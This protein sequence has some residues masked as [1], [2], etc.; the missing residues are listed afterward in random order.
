VQ[1]KAILLA[2][3]DSISAFD[4]AIEA[5]T[6]LFQHHH[7]DVVQRFSADRSRVSDQVRLATVANLR[8]TIPR[9]QVKPGQGCI[10]YATSHGTAEG[11]HL[12]QDQSSGYLLHPRSLQSIVQAACGEAPTIMV[13]SG[14]YSG[15]YLR[16]EIVAPHVI[17]M[18]AAAAHRPSFGCRPGAA[19]TYYDD[20]FLQAFPQARTWQGL[21]RAVSSC[22]DVAER[23]LRV[24]PSEPQAFF[25]RRMQDVPIPRP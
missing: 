19:Y 20:C 24:F 7:I 18:T 6:R 5:L 3:D 23:P 12:T 11:L 2:G 25:G 14:C 16:D 8:A 21:H 22:V 17:L 9:L 10:V 13:L 15:T 1:W 4:R